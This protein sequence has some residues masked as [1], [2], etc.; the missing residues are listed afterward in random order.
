MDA[1][2]VKS[3]AEC[4]IASEH[5]EELKRRMR[6]TWAEVSLPTLRRNFRAI[7]KAAG[8]A[9]VCAVVKADAYGHGLVPCARALQEEGASWYGV[10]STEEG[11]ALRDAGIKGRVFLMSGFW[12]GEEDEVIRHRLTPAVWE[13]WQLEALDSALDHHPSATP[14][15]V[16]LKVDTGMGRLGV[17]EACLPIFLR[18]LKRSASIRVEGILS[19]LASADMLD[20]AHTAKQIVRFSRVQ[21]LIRSAGLDADL[22]HIANSAAIASRHTKIRYNFVRPGIL[23]YGYAMPLIARG[24]RNLIS[25]PLPISPVLTWKA[26]VIS[27]QD[28]PSGWQVG[29]QGT[30]TATRPTKLAILPVGYADGF[31]RHLSN[32]GAVIIHGQRVPIVGRVS[33]DLT[34]VDVTDVAGVCVGDH[35]TLLG[36]DGNVAIDATEHARLADTIAYEVLCGIASRVKRIYL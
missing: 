4:H 9:T 11:V 29:Y 5:I 18:L 28:V 15:A 2:A 1:I 17:R 6:P 8:D 3:G 34:T 36:T 31:S 19:H 32:R 26:R 10:T 16:H 35:A 12:R 23:L 33:M 21:R 20:D 22:T 13:A 25:E 7:K 27:I 24:R 14:F 30:W